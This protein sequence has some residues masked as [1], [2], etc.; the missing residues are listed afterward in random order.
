MC[1]TLVAPPLAAWTLRSRTAMPL[2]GPLAAASA[3]P[4][5]GSQ[6]W[7]GTRSSPLLAKEGVGAG[8]LPALASPSGGGKLTLPSAA[9]GSADAFQPAVQGAPVGAAPHLHPIPAGYPP[10]L[11][12]P[13]TMNFLSSLPQPP[14][15]TREASTPA[16]VGVGGGAQYHHATSAAAAAQN[17]P[18]RRHKNVAPRA[19]AL[20]AAA[21]VTRR[22]VAGSSTDVGGRCGR[23]RHN[24]RRRHGA[25]HAALPGHRDAVGG[26]RRGGAGTTC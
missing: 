7:G 26:R 5:R 24:P 20:A 22:A 16:S 9:G 19:V 2:H 14:S 13:Q 15:L 23:R 6:M 21:L 3:P 25:T 10:I 4:P 18:A 11:R 12:H 17:H 8:R 1:A